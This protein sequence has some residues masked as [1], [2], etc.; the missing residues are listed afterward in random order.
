MG[1]R[2]VCHI[3]LAFILLI[4]EGSLKTSSAEGWTTM[5]G[6]GKGVCGSGEQSQS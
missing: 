1:N 5:T 6:P 3:L 2:I 4:I